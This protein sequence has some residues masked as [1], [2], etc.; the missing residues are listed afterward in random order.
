MPAAYRTSM[1]DRTLA[2][3][4]PDVARELS[5]DLHRQQSTLSMIASESYTASAVMAAQGS[6]FM[7]K[8]AEGYAGHRYCSGCEHV[9]IVERLAVDRARDLF[10]ADHVNVQPH[11]GAQANAAVYNALL[12]A[13]DTILAMDLSHGGHLTHG[14]RLNF[15][16][17]F[18]QCVAYHVR[19]SDSTVDMA[20]VA[21][22][23]REHRPKLIVAG[24]SAYPRQLD[25]AEFCRIADE[26]GAYLMV[27][28][29]HF[30]GL[31]AGGVHANPVPYADVV[32]ST[33]HKTLGG[34]RGGMVLCRKELARKIDA[35]VFPGQ[36]AAPLAHTIAAKAV[37]FKIAATGEFRDVQRR[38]VDGARIIAGRL[39]R[40]DLAADGIK[41]LSGGT[42]VH[43]LL[44]DLRESGL[45]GKDAEDRLAEIGISVNRNAVPFDPRPPMVTSGLRV[46][47]SALA[48]R[49]FDTDSFTE[50][51]DI[52]A[53]ALSS[54]FDGGTA[55]VLHDRVSVLADKHPLYGSAEPER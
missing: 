19:P 11:S 53:L 15:S 44:V 30:A 37:A 25:F 3:V 52:V 34:P 36:Q 4:D 50:V 12:D 29:A 55:A 51:A 32:T 17:R 38:T 6:V 42:D 9:D 27:D 49:G 22:L 14:M 23:A 39:A 5:A 35:G 20:E 33:T 31:V 7:N 13:G 47:T 40:P 18:Y 16:A 41:I 10:G 1:I 43:M 48:W 28:M 24:W 54:R 45:T 46:G 21:R 8:L 26:A 2:E